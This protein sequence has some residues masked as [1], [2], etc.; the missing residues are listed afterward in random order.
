MSLARSGGIELSEKNLSVLVS[1]SGLNPRV[2]HQS[3]INTNLRIETRNQYLVRS[4]EE[5]VLSEAVFIS[6]AA[7]DTFQLRSLVQNRLD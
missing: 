3:Y 6:L 2:L 5:G 1:S 7:N 4:E